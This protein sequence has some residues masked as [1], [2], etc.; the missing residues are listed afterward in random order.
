[1]TTHVKY[2]S[3][4][5]HFA[6]L[7]LL[8]AEEGVRCYRYVDNTGSLSLPMAFFRTKEQLEMLIAQAPKTFI[9][10][11]REVNF[12]HKYPGPIIA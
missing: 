6:V 3:S 1:M 4:W 5:G 11:L 10:T 2:V 9:P 8:H 12:N 7:E